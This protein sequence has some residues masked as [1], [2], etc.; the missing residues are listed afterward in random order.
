MSD[1]FGRVARRINTNTFLVNVDCDGCIDKI[2]C[3]H[4]D[5]AS[6]SFGI[7]DYTLVLQHASEQGNTIHSTSLQQFR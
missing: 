4:P 6:C 3:A 2:V 5:I 1:E 7:T